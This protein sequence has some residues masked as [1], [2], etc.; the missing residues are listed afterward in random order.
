MIRHVLTVPAAFLEVSYLVTGKN[1][2]SFWT[3]TGPVDQTNLKKEREIGLELFQ[4][5]LWIKM[6]K[7]S[8]QIRVIA[9]NKTY[10]QGFGE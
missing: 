2:S 8:T 9:A 5:F 6:G 4:C 10:L 3:V 1:Y 7:K